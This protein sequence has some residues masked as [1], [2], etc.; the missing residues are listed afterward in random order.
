MLLLSTVSGNRTLSPCGG[1][2]VLGGRIAVAYSTIA[3]NGIG[4]GLRLEAAASGSVRGTLLTDNTANCDGPT[5]PTS[6]GYNLEDSTSC[7]LAGPGDRSGID[8]LL[9]PL[10]DN[11]G[12]TFTHALPA[13]SAAVDASADASCPATDQREVPCPQGPVATP[14]PTR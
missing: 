10:A 12:P 4:G 11:G 1:I 6:L 5:T 9:G 8:P 7:G 3:D 13:G 14:V 2:W